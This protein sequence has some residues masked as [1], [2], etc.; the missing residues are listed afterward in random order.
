MTT[1]NMDLDGVLCNFNGAMLECLPNE[2]WPRLGSAHYLMGGDVWEPT[3]WDW[4]EELGVPKGEW[5]GAFYR[6]VR[7]RGLWEWADA[8]PGVAGQLWRLS[9][10]GVYVRIVTTRL[11]HQGLHREAVTQTVNWL[12]KHNI[13]YRSLAFETYKSHFSEESSFLLDDNVRN[14]RSF[15]T[16]GPGRARL[17]DR[18]WNQEPLELYLLGAKRVFSL[19]EFVNEV[20]EYHGQD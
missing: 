15:V 20:L 14:V 11:V 19:G 7:E 3:M 2:Y 6:G 13:P 4:W 5:V 12:E 9:D 18:P 8:Y 10:A 16:D 17:L 1:V